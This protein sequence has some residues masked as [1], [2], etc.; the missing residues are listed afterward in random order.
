MS[1]YF[2]SVLL[3]E[4]EDLSLDP[5]EKVFDYFFKFIDEYGRFNQNDD[6]DAHD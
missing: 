4:S 5:N 3:K 2:C 6:T 1:D